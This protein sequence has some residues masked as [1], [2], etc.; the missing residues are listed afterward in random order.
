M[1]YRLFISALTLVSLCCFEAGAQENGGKSKDS[2][3]SSS[4]IDAASDSRPREISLGLPTTK[5]GNVT[6]YEDGLPV[7]VNVFP[8]YPFKIWH[9]G[10]SSES[11]SNLGP[12]ETA[13]R[14]NEIAYYVYSMNRTGIGSGT[15]GAVDYTYGHYGQHKLDVNLH[16]PIAK[17]GWYYSLSTYQNFDP[18]S[19]RM[20]CTKYKD[21]HQFYKG[22]LSKEFKDG[23]GKMSL[24]LQYVDYFTINEI[25]GPFVFVGNGS[26]KEM[27]GFRLGH[28]QYLP[29]DTQMTFMDFRT[30]N[31]VTKDLN[32]DHRCNAFTTTFNLSYVFDQV[33]DLV[34]R[35]RYEWTDLKDYKKTLGSI[36]MV[37]KSAGFTYSDGSPYS[38][39]V[40][41][42]NFYGYDSF[43]RA[44]MNNAEYRRKFLPGLVAKFG[45]DFNLS[46][47]PTTLSSAA[48]AHEVCANPKSLYLNGNAYYN[49]NT[50]GQYYDG[51]ETKTTLYAYYDWQI[52]EK[53]ASEGF[54]RAGAN[55]INGEAANN[56]G[57]DTSNTRYSGFNLTKAK[58]TEVKRFNPE[59]SAGFNIRYKLSQAIS[60]N[61]EPI[62]TSLHPTLSD[63]CT[64]YLPSSDPTRT[65]LL[66][67]GINYSIK[68]FNLI[69]QLT[70]LSQDNKLERTGFSH[71]LTK[72][73]GDRKAG[74]YESV[75]LPI[76][77]GISSFGLTV[78]ANWNPGNGF[79]LHGMLLLRNPKF[80]NFLFSHTFS[81]GVNESR[82]FSGNHITSMPQIEF[83]LDPSYSIKQWRFWLTARYLSREYINKTNSLFFS[84]R[85]E[86]FAGIDFTLNKHIKLKLNFINLLNQKGANGSIASAD[87]LED[88]SKYTNYLMSGKFIRP[89]TVEAGIKI[90]L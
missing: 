46:R 64:Q 2:Q 7:C 74:T 22:V 45:A 61:L 56:I 28:D 54:V 21:R 18:G 50:S 62:I 11:T 41:Y 89:F 79:K 44:W 81:D 17:N 5:N 87:L 42:R 12:M 40:Q 78:D 52:A 49:F 24:A 3:N 59:W 30:G 90:N 68:T 85:V 86:T 25:Y 75:V 27:E 58:I 15:G 83:T 53:W 36:A 76:N 29:S 37:D 66:R 34:V 55:I 10:V 14:Y 31:M 77:Y 84:G 33:S 88:T 72:D 43:E 80:K 23:K 48:L 35:S 20:T 60:F 32:K 38:G 16:G 71:Q 6:I 4:F 26:V 8:I 47:R 63:Y 82:D 39:N 13:M 19:N 65:F 1:I 57:D 51:V 73:V 69:A 9:G 70:Y 67:G